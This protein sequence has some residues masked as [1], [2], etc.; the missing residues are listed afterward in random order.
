VLSFA[1]SADCSSNFAHNSKEK[2]TDWEIIGV[3]LI[4][5]FV[6]LACIPVHRFLFPKY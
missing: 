5:V 6:A 1:C 3:I 4:I 2:A